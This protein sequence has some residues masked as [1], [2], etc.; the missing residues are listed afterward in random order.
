MAKKR[1]GGGHG[2][3]KRQ[4]AHRSTTSSRQARVI[5]VYEPKPVVTYGQ[6]FIV[7]ED[8]AKNTFVYQS[9]AWVPHTMSMA[10]CHRSC[11]VKQLPQKMNRMTRYEV[12]APV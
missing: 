5:P 12:R 6:P 11:Q 1:Y 2:G 8:E 10:E 7:M 3:N 4:Q 9:G